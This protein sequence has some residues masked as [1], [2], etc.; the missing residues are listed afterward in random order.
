MTKEFLEELE[1]EEQVAEAIWQRHTQTVQKLQFD[2]SLQQAIAGAGGRNAK[3][4]TALLDM[5]ALQADPEGIPQAL[6]QLKAEN[7]YLFEE[8]LPRYAK[9][10]GTQIPQ[11]TVPTTLAGAL[12]ERFEK[13]K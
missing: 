8:K 5:E 3:A 7:S 11:K 1:L 10:T 4:I 6:E 2:H 13:S 9:G 12:R